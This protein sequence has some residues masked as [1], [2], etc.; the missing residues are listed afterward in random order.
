MPRGR[1]NFHRRLPTPISLTSPSLSPSTRIQ[2]LLRPDEASPESLLIPVHQLDDEVS[3]EAR[4]L[5]TKVLE[6]G[7]AHQGHAS[8]RA[9]GEVQE[10]LLQRVVGLVGPVLVNDAGRPRPVVAVNDEPGIVGSATAPPELV[11]PL[12]ADVGDGVV[13][14]ARLNGVSGSRI[15]LCSAG[16]VC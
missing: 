4:F 16:F 10:G 5:A 1:R 9:A 14:E 13:A 12:L 3:P 15:V 7:R 11:V 8:A 2:Q 6:L